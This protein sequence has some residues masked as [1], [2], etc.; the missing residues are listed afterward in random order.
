MNLRPRCKYVSICSSSSSTFKL[1]EGA[2]SSNS[3]SINVVLSVT[4][5]RRS[6]NRKKLLDRRML[7]IEFNLSRSV[8]YLDS[9]LKLIVALYETILS[10]L[11]L[12]YFISFFRFLLVFFFWWEMAEGEREEERMETFYSTA[13][14]VL[15]FT[16]DPSTGRTNDST[17]KREIWRL[18]VRV[19]FFLLKSAALPRS[20][21][22]RW[23]SF[24]IG[25]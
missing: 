6:W 3:R 20:C 4:I 14:W 24:L 18:R 25:L 22:F 10:L 11:F 12:F 2:S 8:K 21:N 1:S 9:S 17:N 23:E 13:D 16:N 5:F 15:P 7:P 19:G